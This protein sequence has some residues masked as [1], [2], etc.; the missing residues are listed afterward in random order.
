MG[1]PY[2]QTLGNGIRVLVALKSGPKSSPQLIA[3]TGIARLT[4]YRILRTLEAEGLV[5][6]VGENS[7]YQLSLRVW[8]LGQ[9]A[10]VGARSHPETGR[11]VERL[12]Q[13]WGDTVHVA[14]YDVG[15]VIYVYKVDGTTHLRAYTTLGGRAPA[16][17]VASG[18]SLLAFQPQTE[19]D[20]VMAEPLVPHT[21]RSLT[22]PEALAEEL[23]EARRTLTAVNR[24]EWRPGIGGV[25]SPIF[26]ASGAPVAA[27]SISGFADRI[28]DDRLEER[29]AQVRDAARM[30]ALG[31]AAEEEAGAIEDLY[32]R[33]EAD[34]L[35]QVEPV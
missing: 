34:S 16:T 3:E 28:V 7:T 26:A 18:K 11:Q 20:R 15:E 29:A 2:L 10:E 17:A 27:V 21:E 30:I 8:E 23:A 6:R 32:R 4:L 1:T 35:P 12:R 25:A 19:I 24:G 5:L 31:L 33:D 14:V 22:S 13:T 9:S